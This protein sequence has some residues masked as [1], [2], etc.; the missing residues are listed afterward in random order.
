[1]SS[2]PVCND[3]RNYRLNW[4]LLGP[5]TV[6]NWKRW[7]M[8]MYFSD[9]NMAWGS[10]VLLETLLIASRTGNSIKHS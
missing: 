10:Q 8:K 2:N 3:T 6:I 1:M 7:P 9:N 5:I 4:T